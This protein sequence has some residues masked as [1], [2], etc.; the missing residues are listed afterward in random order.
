MPPKNKST[1]K[2]F[3]RG[4]SALL[5]CFSIILIASWVVIGY[6]IYTNIKANQ[7]ENASATKQVEQTSAVV[8]QAT[9]SAKLASIPTDTPTI[10]PSPTLPWTGYALRLE[11]NQAFAQ[12]E[13]NDSLDALTAITL[14]AWLRT[15][16]SVNDLT[17]ISKYN[18][19]VDNLDAAF[20]LNLAMGRVHFQLASGASYAELTSERVVADGSWH[21]IAA[22]WDGSLMYIYIDGLLDSSHEYRGAGQINPTNLPVTIGRTLNDGQPFRFFS[23]E[24][25]EIRIWSIPRTERDLNTYRFQPLREQEFGL[26]AYW[27]MND[28][29]SDAIITDQSGKGNSGALHGGANL[30]VSSVPMDASGVKI[31]TPIALP[32]ITFTPAPTH[33]SG[34]WAGQAISL[35][36]SNSSMQVTDSGFLDDMPALTLEAWIQTSDKKNNIS[37][38]SKYNHLTNNLDDAYYLNIFEGVVYFQINAGDSFNII[39]GRKVVADNVW[40]HIAA[41]WDG[42]TMVIFVDGEVDAIQEYTGNGRINANDLPVSIGSSLEN[43]Q[44]AFFFNGTIDEVRI[45][46]IPR[47]I[48]QI[49]TYRAQRLEG[50]EAGLVAYWILDEASDTGSI[51]DLTRHDHTGQLQG[52]AVLIVSTIPDIR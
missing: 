21:H 13:D 9:T 20:H 40:H 41:T 47:S 39:Q 48:G 24:L 45:W 29:P 51:A 33:P 26:K 36:G 38:I 32:Q 25:D 1:R 14:E 6:I 30:I 52:G 2:S 15:T 34:S 17:I 49:Q 7:V 46:S 35:D 27:N 42:R 10:T 12:I 16:D 28:S 50:N 43:S 37:I 5:G 44:Q 8:M 22:V 31:T 18:H 23:G 3:S 19:F 11:S 4:Q